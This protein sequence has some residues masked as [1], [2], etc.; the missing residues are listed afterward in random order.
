VR[1]PVVVINGKADRP[2]FAVTAGVRDALDPRLR[3]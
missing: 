2:V 1:V 3:P